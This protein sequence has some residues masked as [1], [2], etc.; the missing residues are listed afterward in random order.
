MTDRPKEGKPKMRKALILT[1]MLAGIGGLVAVAQA[2]QDKVPEKDASEVT[3]QTE[4]LRKDGE[5][6]GAP[7]DERSHE[8]RERSRDE[9]RRAHEEGEDDDQD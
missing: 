9:H 1:T 7:R 5:S 8:A 6:L 3:T 4:S 2:S